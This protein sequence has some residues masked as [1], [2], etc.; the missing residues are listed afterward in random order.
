MS[1]AFSATGGIQPYT[2]TMSNIPPGLTFDTSTG[3][4]TG[5]AAGAE[6]FTT[7][8]TVHDSSNPPLSASTT[9]SLQLRASLGSIPAPGCMLTAASGRIENV[10]TQSSTSAQAFAASWQPA[11]LT[12]GIRNVGE[13]CNRIW[14]DKSAGNSPRDLK[15]QQRRHP[16]G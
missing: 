14:R 8:V 7:V 2:W 13:T 16:N 3:A 4:L 15:N 11:N 1:A 5:I 12:R 9:F 6:K 10:P